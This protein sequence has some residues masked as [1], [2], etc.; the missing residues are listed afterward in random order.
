MV[1]RFQ[2]EKVIRFQN[3]KVND[4][5]YEERLYCTAAD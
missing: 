3:K 5:D 4:N 1:I 2:T